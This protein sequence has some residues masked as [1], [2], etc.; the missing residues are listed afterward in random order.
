MLVKAPGQLMTLGL[1]CVQTDLE[2]PEYK[3]N[4]LVAVVFIAY[5]AIKLVFFALSLC[6]PLGA[7]GCQRAEALAT[8]HAMMSFWLGQLNG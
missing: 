8:G 5:S 4:W 2:K 7:V 1:F 3:L 6:L